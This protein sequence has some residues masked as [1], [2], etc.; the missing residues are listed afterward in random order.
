MVFPIVRHTN[1][2]GWIPEEDVD[3]I[4][5]KNTILSKAV[6]VDFEN[7]FLSTAP[8]PQTV[9]LN[10]AI[11]DSVANGYAFASV[12]H[13]YDSRNSRG[14]VVFYAMYKAINDW[15]FYVIDSGGA[16]LLYVDEV[17]G[18]NGTISLAYGTE[19]KFSYAYSDGQLKINTNLTCV[20]SSVV[21][22]AEVALSMTLVYTDSKAMSTDTFTEGWLLCPRWLG[23]TMTPGSG[24]KIGSTANPVSGTE[25]F[26]DATYNYGGVINAAD[27]S[28]TGGFSHLTTGGQGLD[29]CLQLSATAASGFNSVGRFITA[30]IYR[31]DKVG[32][33]IYTENADVKEDSVLDCYV[34]ITMRYTL[35]GII[36][37]KTFYS[38]YLP[39]EANNGVY[40]LEQDLGWVTPDGATNTQ[41]RIFVN[42]GD[43]ASG[44]SYAEISDITLYASK[45]MI[46]AVNDDEQRS[47]LG[48]EYAMPLQSY[49]DDLHIA[50]AYVDW[51]I[52]EYEFFTLDVDTG[53]YTKTGTVLLTDTWTISGGW[54]YASIEEYE[55]DTPETLN[56]NYGL[57]TTIRVDNQFYIEDEVFYK[58]KEYAIGKG[59]GP[60]ETLYAH[61]DNHI[62]MTHIAGNGLAQP[63]SFPYDA[64]KSFGFFVSKTTELPTG[65]A[66][67]SLDEITV[68]YGTGNDVYYIQQG[69][70][71]TLRKLKSVNGGQG[72]INSKTIAKTLEGKPAGE[73]LIWADDYGLFAYAGG[74]EAP[75]EVTKETHSEWWK[76]NATAYL[77]AADSYY[78]QERREYWLV[79]DD[80]ILL[81]ELKYNKFRLYQ[82]A[83]NVLGFIGFYDD[84]IHMYT[85]ADSIVKFDRSHT[86]HLTAEIATHYSTNTLIVGKYPIESPEKEI[87]V[88]QE[89]SVGMR[90]G[91]GV[92]P[93]EV[94][95]TPDSDELTDVINVPANAGA[96]VTLSPLSVAY[97]KIKFRI[98][99]PSDSIQFRELAYSFYVPGQGLAQFNHYEDNPSVISG[100]R[101]LTDGQDVLLT[102]GDGTTLQGQ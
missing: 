71:I 21:D 93:V 101:G 7:G 96:F 64:D 100:A 3:G 25:D 2:E 17:A 36:R 11:A 76:Q 35:S 53:L 30:N 70:G 60:D 14:D 50:R 68:M 40:G 38:Q 42:L 15:K 78:D 26:A 65:I 98:V 33:S 32:F 79:L 29:S 99:I 90:G 95:M 83:D 12:K 1:F 66:I 58:G 31:C 52:K 4:D 46:V 72:C 97:S 43:P 63:D 22:P 56:F 94:Y 28:F 49:T 84:A 47:G 39:L 91:Q 44:T 48:T 73:F 20:F 80:I 34:T 6:N 59:L 57:G 86:T 18:D 37:E 89:V 61:I 62:R 45:P 85:D 41:L 102:D 55:S 51:R 16:S 9:T 67:T 81:F 24:F 23:W 74:R 19:P 88:L 69:S 27:V 54:A 75:L 5:I 13:F 8:A 77:D 82:F 87:K 92:N 10:A